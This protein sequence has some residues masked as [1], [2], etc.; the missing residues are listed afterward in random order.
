[1]VGIYESNQRTFTH[2]D[3]VFIRVFGGHIFQCPLPISGQ[4]TNLFEVV[5]FYCWMECDICHRQTEAGVE[6]KWV[7]IQGKRTCLDCFMKGMLWA[8]E[9]AY[10]DRCLPH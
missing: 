3:V 7:V 4:M 10:A 9:D 2:M 8:I 6:S 5:T 1:M